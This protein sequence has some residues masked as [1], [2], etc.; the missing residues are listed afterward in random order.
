M[1]PI[2]NQEIGKDM[3][4][5][6]IS[7]SLRTAS[8]NTTLL[9]AAIAL[10]PKGVEIILY[11]GLSGLPHFNPDLEET[12]QPAVMDFRARLQAAH[13]V[14]IS[15]PEYAHGVIV[16]GSKNEIRHNCSASQFPSHCK[17][18]EKNQRQAIWGQ[19]CILYSLPPDVSIFVL[20]ATGCFR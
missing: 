7:G 12:L 6:A 18:M 2:V 11:D 13:G 5:L 1:T 17:R 4:I 3:E 9:R 14:L 10:A 8:S 15:S 19:Q 16:E 20:T